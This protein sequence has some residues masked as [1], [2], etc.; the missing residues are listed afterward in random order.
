MKTTNTPFTALSL[1]ELDATTGG[2]WVGAARA[3]G[4]KLGPAGVVVGAGLDA[5]DGWNDPSNRNTGDR[6]AGAVGAAFHGATFGVFR[7]TPAY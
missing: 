5:Y 1:T 2:S 4:R 3:V 6:V 7:A